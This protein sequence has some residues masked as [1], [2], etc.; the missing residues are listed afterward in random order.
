MEKVALHDILCD[1]I[2]VSSFDGEAHCY[3]EPPAGK[4]MHYP[5]IVYHHIRTDS[6]YADNIAYKNSKVYTIT[7]IDED[8]DS[9]I[10][11][12]LMNALPYCSSDRNFATEGLSHFV[13]TLF[14]NGPR[15]KEEIQNE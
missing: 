14:Y 3:F 9:K 12:R 2:R 5:C 1:I 6:F 15:I 11:I 8:P 13:Y 10:P 7:I 4:E